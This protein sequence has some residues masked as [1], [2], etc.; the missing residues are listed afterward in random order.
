MCI[1]DRY[2]RRVHGK[3]DLLIDKQNL[4]SF[5]QSSYVQDIAKK[6]KFNQYLQ[7]SAQTGHNIIKAFEVM[8]DI[9]EN[10]GQDFNEISNSFSKLSVIKQQ[11]KTITQNSACC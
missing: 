1:R 11:Q 4:E 7:V 3:Y 2:Q 6:N 9:I 10:L 5:Q 8:I